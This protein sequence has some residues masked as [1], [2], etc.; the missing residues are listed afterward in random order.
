M[1]QRVLPADAGWAVEARAEAVEIARELGAVPVIER[2]E[3]TDVP[4]AAT[5]A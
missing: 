5:G 2:L 1:R 4:S 3:S